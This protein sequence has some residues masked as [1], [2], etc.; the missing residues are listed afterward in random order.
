VPVDH[1][2][3]GPTRGPLGKTSPK[4]KKGLSRKKKI[5]WGCTVLQVNNLWGAGKTSKG[6]EEKKKKDPSSAQQ[7][8]SPKRVGARKAGAH[9]GGNPTER[10]AWRTWTPACIPETGWRATRDCQHLPAGGRTRESKS[11]HHEPG[12]GKKR[13]VSPLGRPDLWVS[14]WV[15]Q[16]KSGELNTWGWPPDDQSCRKKWGAAGEGV[17]GSHTA[18]NGGARGDV[19]EKKNLNTDL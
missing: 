6:D 19:K 14:C 1:W 2:N 15:L 3:A 12:A 17:V 5:S 11:T 4:E 10:K 18:Q 8:Q 13:G 16:Q 7:L 9:E